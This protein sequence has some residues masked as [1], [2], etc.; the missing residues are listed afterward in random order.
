MI[1]TGFGRGMR[2]TERMAKRLPTEA[3]VLELDVNDPDALEAVAGDARRALGP[4]RR[5]PARDRLRPGRRARRPVPAA[6]P[7][8]S[9]V[10]AFETSAF[11]LKALAAAL[12]PLLERG[13]AAGRRRPGLRR[14]RRLAG[15]RLGRASP[16]PRSSRS[17]ATSR[18]TSA[19]AA[20]APT[21]SPPARCRPWRP[22]TSRASRASPRSGS[23]RRRWAGTS[24]T[25]R[26]SPTPVC[27]CSR[28]WRAAITGEILH[29]D[30]GVHAMGAGPVP[31]RPPTLSRPP[32]PSSFAAQEAHRGRVARA[33]PSSARRV[34]PA[35]CSWVR[36][37]KP[38]PI[39]SS[40]A[41]SVATLARRSRGRPTRF[42]R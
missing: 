28:R 29:V 34:P 3:D 35:N 42:P 24:P 37:R 10:A 38:K 13:E 33:Q 19:R 21:S 4:P 5:R 23:A 7:S 30:G 12:L 2:I 22:R 25:P 41:K 31:L 1:L 26:R 11:S 17:T 9:A 6:R 20:C 39:R 18:A 14:Q 32:T 16:R 8:A 27:S 15:L 40:S 36:R